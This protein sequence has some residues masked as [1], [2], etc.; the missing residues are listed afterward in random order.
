[1]GSQFRE[2]S[3]KVALAVYK[4]IIKH[5]LNT[6]PPPKDLETYLHESMWEPVYVPYEKGSFE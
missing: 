3:Y 1:M 4:E 2:V 5:G 6:L